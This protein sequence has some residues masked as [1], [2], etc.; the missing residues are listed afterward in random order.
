VSAIVTPLSHNDA[1]DLASA[2]IAD[3]ETFA[4]ARQ[5]FIRALM[6]VDV[7]SREQEREAARPTLREQIAMRAPACPDEFQPDYA[8]MPG[9]PQQPDG[10]SP[11]ASELVD[12]YLNWAHDPC[13]DFDL[14]E[15]AQQLGFEPEEQ[16]TVLR[17]GAAVD[18]ALLAIRKWRR[19]RPM[20]RL[21]A[22][23]WAYA[24]AVLAAR[25]E[26]RQ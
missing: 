25:S 15:R 6:D 10:L 3:G 8:P 11:R 12:H 17:Y 7:A 22:W 2:C 14:G 26:G 20:K 23:P 21:A 1:Y 5:R 13:Y 19:E 16:A 18:T 9:V 4:Q 24:D